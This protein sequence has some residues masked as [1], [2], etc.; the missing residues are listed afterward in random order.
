MIGTTTFTNESKQFTSELIGETLK[1]KGVTTL[2]GTVKQ[3]SGQIY[4][5]DDDRYVGDYSTNNISLNQTTRAGA[6]VEAA[7][8]MEQLQKDIDTKAKEVQA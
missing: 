2:S 7:Q 4:G 3:F 1:M 6:W 8:M 5:K